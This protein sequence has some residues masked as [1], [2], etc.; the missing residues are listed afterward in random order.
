MKNSKIL[1]L[2]VLIFFLIVLTQVSCQKEMSSVQTSATNNLKVYLTDAPVNFSNV[3]ID[4]Q[5]V[6]VKIEKDSCSGSVQHSEPGDDHGS[7]SGND[8][9]GSGDDHGGNSGNDDN[10]NDDHS[11][12]SSG[13]HH[14][15]DCEVWDTLQIS[16]GVYDLLQFRN[17]VDALLASGD[18]PRGEIKAVRLTLGNNN[19]VVVDSISYPLTL[20]GSNKVTVKID[21][22]E[23]VSS[24]NLQLHLDFDLS[25]SIVQ[26][27]GNHFELRPFIKPF[28]EN[29]SGRVEGR[30]LPKDAKAIVTLTGNL[31]TLVA[32]PGKDGEFKIRGIRSTQFDLHFK[33]T[34]AGYRDSTISNITINPGQEIK[35]GTVTLRR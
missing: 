18:I 34:A 6:E 13:N 29:K 1:L 35:T 22:I 33:A 8:D 17:G 12:D 32:I 21:D 7:N 28:N 20:P 9:H 11:S 27:N 23:T 16:A 24:G 15:E 14:S 31:D 30:V 26:L 19:S 5:M 25:N 3:F 2:P 4:I 10:G